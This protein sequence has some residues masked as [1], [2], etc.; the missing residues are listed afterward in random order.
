MKKLLSVLLLAALLFCGTAP[1]FATYEPM[2]AGQTQTICMSSSGFG[3]SYGYIDTE[4]NLWMWGDNSNSCLGQPGSV[5]RLDQPVLVMSGVAAFKVNS[6]STIVLKTDGTAWTW[7]YDFNH[8]VM[9]AWNSQPLKEKWTLGYGPQPYFISDHVTAIGLG[10]NHQFGILKDDGTLWTWGYDYVCNLGYNPG[11][12]NLPASYYA[13]GGLAEGQSVA[14]NT[15][16]T[17]PYK[18]LDN[19]KSFAMGHYNGMAIKNDNTLW[20]WGGN[21]WVTGKAPAVGYTPMKIL[22]NVASFSI[23]SVGLN[24]AILTNG[25][26]WWWGAEMRSGSSL[27]SLAKRKKLMDNVKYAV[28]DYTDVPTLF[29][30]D[31]KESWTQT[32]IVKTDGKLYGMS[33]KEY[34]MDNVVCVNNDLFLKNDGSLYERQGV[35]K[36]IDEANREFQNYEIV[37]VADN[38]AMP[39]QPFSSLRKKIG[40]F[41][42]VREGD[43]F[44][45]PVEWAVSKSITA[46]TTPTTFSP[47]QT[48][49]TAQILTFLWVAAGQNQPKGDNPFSDVSEANYFYRPAL[50]ASENGLVEGEIF[51]GNTPCTRSAV[52]TYLWKLAGSPE[53]AVSSQF[54]DVP[55][56]AAYAQAV[57]WAVKEG[58]TAGL[59]A[60]SFGPDQVCTRAQIVTFLKAALD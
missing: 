40:N 4:G 57:A 49:T 47:N 14:D 28:V 58:V 3:T 13:V 54:T 30:D 34:L 37:K 17:K 5:D 2:T 53:T 56:D 9:E 41:T 44:A 19:V 52:V 25:E 21:N 32:Y 18:V 35:Y 50:W 6:G 51:G 12:V 33:G 39:G 16:P 8:G 55:A 36:Q 31:S 23:G 11:D 20:Y 60:T 42:D 29:D 22:D 7:G 59:S 38:V 15:I 45:S 43:W 1:V 26:F 10:N 24:G 27:I 48:C 46:G